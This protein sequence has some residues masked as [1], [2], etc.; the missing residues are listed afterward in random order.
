MQFALAYPDRVQALVLVDPA[1]YEG[2]GGPAWVNLLGK[3]P[4]VQH[5]GPL[6]VRSIQN[7]G[8]DLVRVAWHNPALITQET[9]EGY[10]KPLQ[11]DN[12]DQALWDLTLASHDT[13]LTSHLR[14]YHLPILVITGD[15]DRIVP[16]ADS[17]RLAN[18]LPGAQLAVIPD[19][20]HV[21]HEEQPAVFLQAVITF[22]TQ[23]P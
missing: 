8:K 10:T 17:L 21:P 7:S 15:D 2:S 9:W 13:G 6:L 3:L 20:G 23:L 22:I 19:A 18:D 11:A 14:D 12:W 5:L 16:T 1:V 4:Q